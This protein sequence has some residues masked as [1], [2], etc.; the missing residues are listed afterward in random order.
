VEAQRLVEVRRDQE[1]PKTLM[2]GCHASPSRK[3]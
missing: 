2:G 3:T 1:V